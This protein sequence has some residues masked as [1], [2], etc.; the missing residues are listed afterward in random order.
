MKLAPT[1]RA[2]LVLGLFALAGA[3]LV[4]GIHQFTAPR[5]ADNERRVLLRGIHDVIP[6]DAYDNDV[7]RDTVTVRDPRLGTDEPVT[8]YIAR[9]RGR[10]VGI[11][12][13][14]VAPNGY[15]GA[16]HLLVGILADGTVG[17][18]RV[19]SHKETPGLGDKIERSHSDW[20]LAF[21]GRRLGDPPAAR[22]AVKRDGGVFDQFTGATISPRAV[23]RAVKNALLYFQENRERLFAES[24]EARAPKP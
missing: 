16:I 10:P 12:L 15:G 5:I 20:I 11:I 2:P 4:A 13:P 21:T 1:L 22:W 18:V 23:V 19:L 14:V 24:A 17:G 7:L 6:E 8:A 3:L 9:R